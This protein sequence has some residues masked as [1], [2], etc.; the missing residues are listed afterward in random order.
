MLLKSL[1]L[2]TAGHIILRGWCE[3]YTN[4]CSDSGNLPFDPKRSRTS[5][6]IGVK[7]HENHGK[8]APEK[9]DRMI[10][11]F[12]VDDTGCGMNL[13]SFEKIVLRTVLIHKKNQ[14]KTNS[15]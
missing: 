9:D 13:N 10:L 2:F 8:K 11:W 6:K 12:E 1:K 5:Q 7:Q 3:N 4:Y 14:F 15:W